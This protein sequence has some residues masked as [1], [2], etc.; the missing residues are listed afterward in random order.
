MKKHLIAIA[1]SLSAYMVYAHYTLRGGRLNPSGS[2][3]VSFFFAG[4]FN[5]TLCVLPYV[6]AGIP[7]HVY[8]WPEWTR[9]IGVIVVFFLVA[10]GSVEI[11]ANAVS[12]NEQLARIIDTAISSAFWLWAASLIHGIPLVLATY[13]LQRRTTNQADEKPEISISC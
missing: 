6:V 12:G 3:V 11:E 7:I 9:L 10:L 4:F 1:F 13:Y 2:I 5:L 8:Q